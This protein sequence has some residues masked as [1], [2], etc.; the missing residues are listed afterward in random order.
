MH[1]EPVAGAPTRSREALAHDPKPARQL[2]AGDRRDRRNLDEQEPRHRGAKATMLACEKKFVLR[3]RARPSPFVLPPPPL[4][5]SAGRVMNKLGTPHGEC[6]T[7]VIPSLYQK[8]YLRPLARGNERPPT[9]AALGHGPAEA[10]LPAAA[11]SPMGIPEI[12][13][14]SKVPSGYLGRT[15][16]EPEGPCRADSDL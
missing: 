11:T 9:S 15:S 2:A 13:R 3:R 16:P 14:G 12:R 10:G 8:F 4:C 5:R 7:P 6:A 1:D